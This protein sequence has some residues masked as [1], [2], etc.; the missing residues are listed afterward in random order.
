MIR[1]LQLWSGGQYTS[2]GFNR[3]EKGSELELRRT[4]HTTG[5]ATRGRSRR[6]VVSPAQ[7][8]RLATISWLGWPSK[9]DSVMFFRIPKSEADWP[10]FEGLVLGCI[11]ADF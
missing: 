11:G 3:V 1:R 8:L 7:L 6:R 9:Q 2:S 10:N 4:R 5:R